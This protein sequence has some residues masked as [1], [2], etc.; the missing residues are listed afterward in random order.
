MFSISAPVFRVIFVPACANRGGRVLFLWDI[1]SGRKPPPGW[2]GR[3]ERPV[4]AAPGFAN[5]ALN[6]RYPNTTHSAVPDS[7]PTPA[8][9]SAPGAGARGLA[10]IDA[11]ARQLFFASA[12]SRQPPTPAKLPPN[13][14]AKRHTPAPALCRTTGC[15][16]CR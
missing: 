16:P 15:T 10:R 12:H 1:L 7:A 4:Q 11:A 8:H 2:L 14:R 5:F 9:R 13:I 3:A 6:R